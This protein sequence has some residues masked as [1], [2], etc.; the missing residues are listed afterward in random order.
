MLMLITVGI[1]IVAVVVGIADS[2]IL[3]LI[4]VG[5]PIVVGIADPGVDPAG[6]I[7]GM[8]GSGILMAV[9]IADPGDVP[10]ME[11]GMGDG[12]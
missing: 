3:M 7:V 9:G 1:S 11:V 4:T 8:A 5:I 6:G 2:G 12:M 10:D